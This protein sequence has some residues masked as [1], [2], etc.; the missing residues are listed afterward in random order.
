[1]VAFYGPGDDRIAEITA[2]GIGLRLYS[3]TP[4]ANV[5]ET[6]CGTFAGLYVPLCAFGAVMFPFQTKGA[7]GRQAFLS[8]IPM[9]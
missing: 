4:D 6:C 2:V 3:V 5:V 7:P 8:A 9:R 1:M